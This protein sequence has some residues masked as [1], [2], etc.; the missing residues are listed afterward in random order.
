[1]SLIVFYMLAM[2]CVST[3]A[4]VKKELGGWSWAVLQAVGMTVL[5]YLGAWA[6]FAL[7]TEG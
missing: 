1:M 7:L 6:A 3:V 2:Q 4:I 5:A